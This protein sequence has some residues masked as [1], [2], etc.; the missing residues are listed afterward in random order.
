MIIC[1]IIVYTVAKTLVQQKSISIDGEPLEHIE[2]FSYL[3]VLSV[4][5]AVSEGTSKPDS[6]KS[7]VHLVD[8]KT[9]GRLNSLA[10]RLKCTSTTV[11]LSLCYCIALSAGKL[12]KG[13]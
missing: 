12:S 7:G 10:L 11:A 2:E 1:Y 9:P 3:G 4:R 13:S 6:T 5:I 8:S